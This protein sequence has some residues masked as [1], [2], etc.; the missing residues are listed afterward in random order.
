VVV[1]FRDL[2]FEF[3]IEQLPYAEEDWQDGGGIIKDI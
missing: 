3:E 2:E 1:K